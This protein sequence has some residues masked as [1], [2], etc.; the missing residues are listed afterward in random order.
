MFEVDGRQFDRLSEAEAHLE[1][2][3][4]ETLLEIFRKHRVP[5][6]VYVACIDDILAAKTRLA[7]FF[8]ATH[9]EDEG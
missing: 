5:H 8:A 6:S 9:E 3:A 1:N 7:R 2:A 4:A